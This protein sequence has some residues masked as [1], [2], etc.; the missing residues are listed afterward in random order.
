M[1]T[2]AGA[3]VA[4][5]TVVI[6][7]GDNGG[8]LP[9]TNTNLGLRAGKGSAYEGGTRV[10]LIVRWPGVVRAGSTSATPVIGCDLYPS[11]LEMAGA[12]P[13][14]EQIVDGKSI[15]P[16]L[17]NIRGWKRDALFWH[18]PHYHPGGATPYSAIRQ[19]D[20][21]LIRFYEDDRMELYDLRNDPLEQKDLAGSNK[22]K[23]DALRRRL[24]D[25]LKE[26]GA[27]R[28]V[29]NPG[30]DAAKAH[31]TAAQAKAQGLL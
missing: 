10:P 9:A 29:P 18:Y 2:L 22:S 3:G 21:K 25:W 11:I 13:S 20:W 5:R 23:R 6:V 12:K 28:P 15:V 17:R 7:T 19:E 30:H 16:L 24:D 14:P 26:V 31:L 8:W 4:D 27:Q 1:R